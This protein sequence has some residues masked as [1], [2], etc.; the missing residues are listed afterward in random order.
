MM[1][2]R[3]RLVGLALVFALLGG[4]CQSFK[5]T[6][7]QE[8]DL[9]P[10]LTPYSYIEEGTLVAFAIDT[11]ATRR[12]AKE[13]YIPIA[14][15]VANIGLGR[16][17]LGRESFTL[18]DDTGK[19]YPLAVFSEIREA[20]LAIPIDFRLSEHFEG[21][22]AGRFDA[23]PRGKLVFFPVLGTAMRSTLVDRVVLPKFY[24]VYDMLYFPHPEG[25][26]LGRRY[27][28]LLSAKEL[29]HP[30]VVKF[31]IK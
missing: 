26:L 10:R 12:H 18:I 30:I 9:H 6:L 31:R 28:M 15:G 20:H 1:G 17:S 4:G 7:P 2:S 3:I 22:F 11:A 29:P 8:E 19:R 23:W 27:E 5:G 16:L 25:E 21:A 13:P 14:L 24:W